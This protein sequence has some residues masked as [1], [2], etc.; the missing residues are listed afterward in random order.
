M[1]VHKRS[2]YVAKSACNNVNTAQYFIIKQHTK[3]EWKIIKIYNKEAL[4]EAQIAN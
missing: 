3:P 1:K 4:D 2:F